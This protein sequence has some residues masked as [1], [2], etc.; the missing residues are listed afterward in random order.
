MD[1]NLEN[2]Y[3]KYYKSLDKYDYINDYNE[4]TK[5]SNIIYI[6]KKTEKKNYGVFKNY[7]EN[8]IFEIINKKNKKLYIY[9]EENYIFYKK[10]DPTLKDILSDFINNNFIFNKKK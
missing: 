7:R 9:P 2:I 1:E 8:A 5:N 6:N 4:I 10:N 3:K